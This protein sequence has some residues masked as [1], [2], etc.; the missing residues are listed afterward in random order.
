VG[1]DSGGLMKQAGLGIWKSIYIRN[2]RFAGVA[3]INCDS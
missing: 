2:E 1:R 3:Y